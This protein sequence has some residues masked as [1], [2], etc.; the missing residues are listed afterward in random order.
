[1]QLQRWTATQARERLSD[2]STP[3]GVPVDKIARVT[4]TLATRLGRHAISRLDVMMAVQR[5]LSLTEGGEAR[6]EG[7]PEQE[8]KQDLYAGLDDPHLLEQLDEVAI[9]ALGLRL[10]PGHI[11]PLVVLQVG[12]PHALGAALGR[13]RDRARNPIGHAH[14]PRAQGANDAVG[15]G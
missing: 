10:T 5:P 11:V 7:K 4:L 1:M 14:L 6:R 2:A 13:L 15:A 9:E 8:G 12:V 3:A